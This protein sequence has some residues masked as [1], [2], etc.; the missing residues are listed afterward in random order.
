MPS[1]YDVETKEIGFV[2][3]MTTNILLLFFLI[4]YIFSVIFPQG[5]LILTV[6]F[7]MVIGAFILNTKGRI[8]QWKKKW[9]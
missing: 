4:I 5:M 8:K 9:G 1:K 7:V 2:L 6:I 3:K